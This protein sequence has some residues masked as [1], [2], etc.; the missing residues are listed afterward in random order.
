MMLTRRRLLKFGASASLLALAPVGLG[1]AWAQKAPDFGAPASLVIH[2]S[3]GP[4]RLQVEIADTPAK[5]Q[6]GL[7]GREQLDKNAGM[8]FVF[9]GEQSAHNGFWMFQTLIALD[10]AFIDADGRI[11]AIETMPPCP[12]TSPRECPAYLPGAAYHTALEV[13]AGYFAERGIELG[14][15]VAAPGMAGSCAPS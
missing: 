4:Q 10:I 15:C 13:N 8:L 3:A 7:M 6:Y 1:T 11:V 14:D 12:S 5:R 2:T 9:D